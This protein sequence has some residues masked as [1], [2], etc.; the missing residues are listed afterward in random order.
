[1]KN[2]IFYSLLITSILLSCVEVFTLDS[3]VIYAIGE[4]KEDST[5]LSFKELASGLDK[6]NRTRY[7]LWGSQKDIDKYI[8]CRKNA[9]GES[10][11]EINI[12]PNES[13]IIYYEESIDKAVYANLVLQAYRGEELVYESEQVSFSPLEVHNVVCNASCK[14][15]NQAVITWNFMDTSDKLYEYK[16][17]LYR[18]GD[19]Y[20]VGLTNNIF[21]DTD[22]NCGSKYTYNV[23]PYYTVDNTEICGSIS[24]GAS[25]DIANHS[26]KINSIKGDDKAKKVTIKINKD[27]NA[28]IYRIFRSTYN[29]ETNSYDNFVEIKKTSRSK[30]VDEDLEKGKYKY[31]V[32]SGYRFNKE[33]WGSESKSKEVEI[34]STIPQPTERQVPEGKT[35]IL[36]DNDITLEQELTYFSVNHGSYPEIYAEKGAPTFEDFC[37]IL[38]DLCDDYHVRN[39]VVF[40]QVMCETGTL[41]FRG[42]VSAGQCNFSGIGATG[43]VSGN[44]F[45]SVKDGLEAQIQHL[46][47][48][49]DPDFV[50][51]DK[52]PRYSAYYAG[53]CPYLE[54]MSI[55]H[56]P[57]GVGWA[58]S[59]SYYQTLKGIMERVM[60]Y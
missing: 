57:Y 59:D 33:K 14:D 20:K 11:E 6:L 24:N 50:R 18:N 28:N 29:K 56:N 49:A 8:V 54:W 60:S 43:G 16:F 58:M 2:K 46:R 34:K 41:S 13:S 42:D 52:D 27:S 55:P 3:N 21:I 48:Y 37:K 17:N 22:L 32:Q 1:M 26:T 51:A 12:E 23:E 10:I 35:P 9:L 53:K 19:L 15:Y 30:Y 45:D 36:G 38:N 25:I 4:T 40:A 5:I 31:K 44:S 39:S 47:L 7:V